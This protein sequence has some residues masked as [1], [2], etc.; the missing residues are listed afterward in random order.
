MRHGGGVTSRPAEVVVRDLLSA[1][2]VAVC[3]WR[4]EGRWSAYDGRAGDVGLL[5]SANG[6]HA[7]AE[8]GAGTFLGFFCVGAEAR[9]PGLA[10]QPGVVDVGVG[11]DPTI[12]GR[13]RGASIGRPVLEWVER[14]YPGLQQRAVVQSWNQRSLRLSRRLGFELTGHHEVRQGGV[15]L[16]Y[17]VLRRRR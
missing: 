3:R 10:E 16:D 6:Y 17:L 9:V 2:A 1:E 14:R 15:P 11:L 8:Q 12:I 7:I 4:Y 5:S 13:G